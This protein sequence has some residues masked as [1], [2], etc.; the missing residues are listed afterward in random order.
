VLELKGGITMSR[1]TKTA[2]E[3]KDGKQSGA[4]KLVNRS[5]RKIKLSASNR[6]QFH[7]KILVYSLITGIGINCT[8]ASNGPTFYARLQRTAAFL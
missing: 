1:L 6:L 5:Q 7:S 2:S 4:S 3:F 8:S